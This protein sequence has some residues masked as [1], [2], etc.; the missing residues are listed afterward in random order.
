MGTG[1]FK[2]TAQE[3]QAFAQHIE[4]VIGQIGQERSKLNSTVE[5]IAGGWAGQAA[6][7]YKALQHRF[8]E[9]IESLNGSLRAIKD[10]IELT[11]KYYADT[12]AHQQQ[13][14]SGA[15]G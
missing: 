15:Q 1:Q 10:A 5:N 8:N 13:Q 6:E 7:A 9:D 12:E 14:F 3:M 4:E 11:T 2:M